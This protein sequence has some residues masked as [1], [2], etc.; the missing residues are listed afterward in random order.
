[1]APDEPDVELVESGDEYYHVRFRDPDDYEEIRT[2]EWARQP[3]ESVSAGSEVRTGKRPGTD[4]W[5][6]TSV[7]VKKSVGEDTA[8]ETAKEILEKIKS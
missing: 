6:V 7:L 4:D 2:P 1:M 3:A 5:D 8:P